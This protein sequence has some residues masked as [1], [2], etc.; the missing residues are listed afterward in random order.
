[1]QSSAYQLSSRYDG[2][3]KVDYV[4]LF[5]RHYP[6]RLMAEEIHD[7]ITSSTGVPGK[8]TIQATFF[9][10]SPSAP[11]EMLPDPV[12]WAMKLQDTSEPR[13]NGG[14]A[15]TFMNSF[16][17]GN[18]DTQQRTQA[19]SILQ[20]LTLMNDAF[21]TNRTKVSASPTLQS[22]AKL[23]NDAAM[24]NEIF[25]TFL[26]R[27]P[28]DSERTSGLNFLSKSTTAA[29]KSTAIEDLAW[30]TLNKVDFVF[31]Y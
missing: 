14:N 28:S 18:R 15:T 9:R 19:G 26:G 24:L 21:V 22:I 12:I 1:V 17:R 5:A 30:A 27:M 31:S 29:S 10:S 16:L 8:Y 4:P 20:Q 6:R 25:M 7:A 13:N 11:A 23:P 3:W 2:D